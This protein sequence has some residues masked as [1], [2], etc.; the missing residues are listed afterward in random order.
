M[1]RL[2]VHHARGFSNLLD[3]RPFNAQ[4]E[5]PSVRT[6]PESHAPGADQGRPQMAQGIE[7]R[8]MTA[9]NRCR[10]SNGTLR[11]WFAIQRRGCC[12]RQ[13][14]D[15]HDVPR[16]GPGAQFETGLWGLASLAATLARRTG[17]SESVGYPRKLSIG[18]RGMDDQRQQADFGRQHR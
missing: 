11:A 8:A 6:M 7:D 18:A 15:E 1:W 10:R 17:S 4:L 13:K 16:R 12:F 14:S 3:V 5:R 2:L 9:Q